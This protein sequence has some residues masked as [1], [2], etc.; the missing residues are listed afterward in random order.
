MNAIILYAAVKAANVPVDGVSIGTADD[1]STWT[2]TPDSPEARAVINSKSLAQWKRQSHLAE[3][4]AQ[5]NAKLTSSDWT[6]L[7]D[8]PL[9]TK[10]AWVIY[11]QQLRDLPAVVDDP[12]NPVW[13]TPPSNT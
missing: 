12:A 13:P 2:V 7:A 6:Q 8:T 4:R 1:M 5:R 9:Q 3:L 10:A 11:R